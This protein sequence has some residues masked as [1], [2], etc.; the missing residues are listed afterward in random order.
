MRNRYYDPDAG[1]FTQEDPIGLAGGINLYGFTAGDPVN[2]SDPF[3]LCPPQDDNPN[4]CPG[5]LGALVMLGQMTPSMNR[6]VASFLPQNLATA[7]GGLGAGALLGRVVGL[8]GG[9]AAAAGEQVLFEG[10]KEAFKGALRS[11]LRGVNPRQA[12]AL[13]G[14]LKEGSVDNIRLVTGENGLVA[15]S[16]RAGRNGYQTP[17]RM[18]DESGNL[19]RMAQAAWDRAGRFVHG[20]V[21]K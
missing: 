20:E 15:Y 10:G 12:R 5:K 4:D 6:A 21:W 18:F 1:R 13:F 3:A 17:V 7:V 2:F 11:G 14:R 16:T 9:R 8:F 19:S